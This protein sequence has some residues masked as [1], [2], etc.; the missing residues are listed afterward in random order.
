MEVSSVME[1]VVQ[2]YRVIPCDMEVGVRVLQIIVD[3]RIVERSS[4]MG[5]VVR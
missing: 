2:G 1:V 4:V 5:V 3:K